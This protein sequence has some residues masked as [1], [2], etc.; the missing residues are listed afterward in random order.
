MIGKPNT[1]SKNIIWQYRGGI[2]HAKDESGKW[3]MM[4]GIDEKNE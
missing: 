4:E 1:N 2:C 3:Q